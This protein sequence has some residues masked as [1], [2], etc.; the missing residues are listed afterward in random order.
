M[1]KLYLTMAK[2]N[3]KNECLEIKQGCFKVCPK[4][5]LEHYLILDHKAL[6]DWRNAREI[7]NSR[8]FFLTRSNIFLYDWLLS[9]LPFISF[10]MKKCWFSITLLP[11]QQQV[12]RQ[13]VKLNE[14][15]FFSSS[16]LSLSF[17]TPNPRFKKRGAQ[18][19]HASGCASAVGLPAP[20]QN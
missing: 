11:S 7:K 3:G 20:E 8:K 10:L 12:C 14:S 9:F 17:F 15:P 5:F 19:T 1:K 2:I 18:K 6:S 13:R 4:L 16:L